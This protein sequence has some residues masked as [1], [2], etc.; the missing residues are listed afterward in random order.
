MVGA[1]CMKR[2]LMSYAADLLRWL[3]IAVALLIAVIGFLFITRGPAAKHLRG[4]G[5]DG[6][7]VSPEE[8]QFPL[9]V[10]VLT[11]TVLTTGNRV[12]L[13]LDGNGTFPLLWADLRSAQQS[14]MPRRPCRGEPRGSRPCAG[15]EVPGSAVWPHLAR[16]R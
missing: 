5:A 6:A 1:S 15:D 14:I 9:S 13:A 3:S 2:S 12:E 10:A 8:P 16:P 7:P 4:V 11:G